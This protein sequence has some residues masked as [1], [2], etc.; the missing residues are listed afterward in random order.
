MKPPR[1]QVIPE[2]LKGQDGKIAI[3]MNGYTHITKESNNT[4]VKYYWASDTKKP[5]EAY[6]YLNCTP[7][8]PREDD[9]LLLNGC[10]PWN[11]I[12]C[13]SVLIEPFNLK[14]NAVIVSVLVTTT[15]SVTNKPFFHKENR[16]RFKTII[17]KL[18][19]I[20]SAIGL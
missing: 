20:L 2:E 14:E 6:M 1:K 5:I 12:V 17:D 4:I 10:G 15:R 19:T 7:T 3:V 9:Y 16:D 13:H 18:D 8:I 11:T